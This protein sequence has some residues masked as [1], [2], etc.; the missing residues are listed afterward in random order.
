MTDHPD[1]ADDGSEIVARELLSSSEVLLAE[2][3]R[4]ES[5][6][7][8]KQVATLGSDEQRLLALQ[9]EAGVLDLLFRSRYQ[10]RLL[11]L[12]EPEATQDAPRRPAQVL[13]EWRTAQRRL[14]DLRRD[15][16]RAADQTERL[17]LEHRR[18]AAY[19]R[20]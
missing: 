4:I 9:V 20:G 6:E 7:R 19:Y 8:Q 17:R 5:L 2:L 13:D 16:E 12:E 10:T 15:L 3:R 1:T 18:S 11:E 14:D